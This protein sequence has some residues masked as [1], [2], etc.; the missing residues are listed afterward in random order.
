ML[1][2]ST[3]IGTAE[4]GGG[5]LNWRQVWVL[6]RRELRSA[7]REKTIVINSILIPVFLYP[8]LLWATLSGLM[9]VM[10][11]TEGFQSRVAVAEWPGAHPRLRLNLERDKDLQ[12]LPL[13]STASARLADASAGDPPA[14]SLAAPLRAAEKQIRLGQLDALVQFLPATNSAQL[15]GN[16]QAQITYNESKE[17]SAEARRRLSSLIAEY[18]ADWLKRDARRRGV[19]AAA[20]QDFTLT[21]HNLASEQ[22]MGAFV[23]GLIAP[24]IF[25]VMVAIGCFYPAV[26]SLAGERERQT[27][28]TLM[29][30]ATSRLSIVTAKYLYVATVGGLA[31][32][33]NLTAVMVAIGPIFGPLLAKNGRALNCVVPMSALPVAVLAAFLLAGFIAAGM[34]IFASFARTF[35]EG[36]A[37]ITPFYMLVL[38]PIVFLQVPGLGLTFALAC[39]PVVNLTLMV[40]EALSGT[41]HWPQMAVAV[42]ASVALIALCLRLATV[43]IQFEDVFVGGYRGGL[44]RFVQDRFRRPKPARAGAAGSQPPADS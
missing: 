23:L 1:S 6:Y 25:V 10:G 5:R 44:A 32:L 35:K 17:R 19:S 18:R 34:M 13:E 29:A 24:V 33:L 12:I 16:F 8:F 43:I 4:A 14:K 9:F 3:S 42:A 38:V 41:F 31:G 30:S 2:R 40:R 21:S 20:W 26:D 22:Q 36:Q 39:L 7:L 11:L 37:M 15:P 27:W 28:E